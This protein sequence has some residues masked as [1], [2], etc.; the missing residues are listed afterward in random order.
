MASESKR[1][2]F[3]KLRDRIMKFSTDMNALMEVFKPRS[4]K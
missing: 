3:K 2:A 1:T 4:Y